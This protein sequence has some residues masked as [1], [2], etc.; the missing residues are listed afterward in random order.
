LKLYYVF[1]KNMIKLRTEYE[2][3]IINNCRSF[4]DI[5][6]YIDNEHIINM[7]SGVKEHINLYL[8]K[9]VKK[10]LDLEEYIYVYE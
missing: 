3:F 9:K 10:I 5:I 8:E 2:Q 4:D 1:S 6:K 7:L